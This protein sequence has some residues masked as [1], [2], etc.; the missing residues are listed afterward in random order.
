MDYT[1][2][3]TLSY[4]KAAKAKVARLMIEKGMTR[5]QIRDLALARAFEYGKS[6][7]FT[8]GCYWCAVA[9]EVES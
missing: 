1:Q 4:G 6:G 7:E 5:D 3:F 2:D 9:D 8:L